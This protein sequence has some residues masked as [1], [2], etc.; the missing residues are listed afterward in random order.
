MCSS[1]AAVTVT[2]RS[3]KMQHGKCER[4]NAFAKATTSAAIQC[5][6]GPA[7]ESSGA[8]PEVISRL[9]N[10]SELWGPVL[11]WWQWACAS[12]WPA[13]S[14][15]R[16][17][18]P[19]NA[20]TMNPILLINNRYDPATGYR[21]AQVAENRLGNAVLLTL[22]SYGHPTFQL[23]SQCIDDA[24]KRYLVDLVTPPPGTVCSADEA[25]FASPP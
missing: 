7:R 8:W 14:T 11:G 23:R 1:C 10:V 3:W 20:A 5:L 25:P 15:D 6:D 21:N 12:N 17:A 24:R 4:F 22:D 13:R 2:R 9:S 16:Y 19:W 18:G